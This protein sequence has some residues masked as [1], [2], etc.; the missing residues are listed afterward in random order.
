MKVSVEDGKYTYVFH[1]EDEGFMLI[2]CM[3]VEIDSL[4]TEV[5]EQAAQIEMLRRGFKDIIQTA[6]QSVISYG[7][8]K[9]HT[10]NIDTANGAL[11]LSTTPSQALEVFAAKVREQCVER[12]NIHHFVTGAAY[13]STVSSIK[14]IKELP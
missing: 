7:Y 5:T 2:Y 13:H 14:G 12:L 10:R 9:A 6:K 4:R 8:D 3:V 1:P 11:T